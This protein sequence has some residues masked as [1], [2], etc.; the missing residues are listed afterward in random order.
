MTTL[1]DGRL[2]LKKPLSDVEVGACHVMSCIAL[3][4]ANPHPLPPPPPQIETMIERHGL[5]GD[6]ATELRDRNLKLRWE[7]GDQLREYLKVLRTTKH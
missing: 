6:A 5:V 3:S 1:A 2:E 7:Q 4:R